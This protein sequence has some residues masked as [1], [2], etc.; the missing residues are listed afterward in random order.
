M[1]SKNKINNTRSL[2]WHY[3][4]VIVIIITIVQMIAS[5]I[6]MSF[7]VLIDPLEDKYYWD[8]GDI[9]IAYAISCIVT[10]LTSP[11]AGY[12]GD[13]YGAR[14][15]MYLGTILFFI[16]AISTAY[17]NEL[18]QLYLSFGLILGLAQSILLVPLVPAAMIWFKKNLGL[19]MGIILSSWGIGPALSVL[20][21][22]FLLKQLGWVGT[23]WVTG[24]FCSILMLLLTSIFNNNPEERGLLPYGSDVEEKFELNSTPKKEKIK[25]YSS[26][27]RNTAPYWNMSAI[28]FLGCVGHAVILVYIIPICLNKDISLTEAAFIFTVVSGLSS[29][30]RFL[31]PMLCEKFGVRSI[32]F[33]SYLLQSLPILILLYSSNLIYIYTFAFVFAIGY[34]GEAGGFAIL[35]R[36][37]YG[38]APMGIPHGF[39]MLGAGIGMA[40]GGWIGG[41]MFDLYNNYDF[42]LVISILASLGGAACI[43]FLNRPN[44]LLIPKWV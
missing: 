7:G 25:E 18:W 20:I 34:G 4:W 44:K 23:F 16:G 22:T 40:L 19:A 31:T 30:T 10:A 21:V 43:L 38:F 29:V 32:M 8:Q 12:L 2:Y 14:K 35:N 36:R 26:Y 1:T 39:Q 27:I 28:H 15:C 37:Y 11:F 41:S 6:R 13:V 42:A 17:A 24:S 9:S 3:A 5:S 33:F